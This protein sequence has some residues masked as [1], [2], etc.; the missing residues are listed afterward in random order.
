MAAKAVIFPTNE[1][2]LT[3]TRSPIWSHIDLDIFIDLHDNG[4]RTCLSTI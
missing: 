1:V 2:I 3:P 4:A